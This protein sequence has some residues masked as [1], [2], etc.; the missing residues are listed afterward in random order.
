MLAAVVQLT[1]GPDVASNLARATA[2]LAEAA[3]RGA[4]LAVLPEN[5]AFMGEHERDKFAIAESL[6][7]NGPILS[8]MKEAARRHHLSLVLGGFP[9]KATATHVIA[10]NKN[11]VRPSVRSVRPGSRTMQTCVKTAS[12]STA[13]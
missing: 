3:R 8:A 13:C 4:E 10:K 1:S 5:F 2:L 9:E 7:D 11:G 6:D 12:C